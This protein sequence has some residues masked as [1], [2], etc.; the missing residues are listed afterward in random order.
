MKLS[1]E[2]AESISITP[3]VVQEMAVRDL[4]EQM[5]AVTGKDEVR[6]R[7]FLIRGT[8][9]SGA[10]RF[11]WTGLDA[12]LEAVRSV[13]ATFPDP[14]PGRP[15]SSEHCVRAVLHGGRHTLEIPRHIG[16][17]KP[18]LR[19]VSFW[20]RLM[21]LAAAGDLRYGGYSYRDRA[22]TYRMELSLPAAESLRAAG[23]ALTYSTLRE[24]IRTEGF[25]AVEFV[26]ER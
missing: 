18:L 2:A 8:L 5:L 4:I 17:K 13:L 16:R 23:P 1:S 22:D 21:E 19:R 9:V 15:F 26:V 24:R 12:D 14:E 10:S 3:V 7:E 11:R 20:D 25:L 6:V